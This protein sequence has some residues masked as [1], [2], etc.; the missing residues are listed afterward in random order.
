MKGAKGVARAGICEEDKR[1]KGAAKA[2][3]FL[4]KI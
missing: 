2:I 3:A 1:A 4:K